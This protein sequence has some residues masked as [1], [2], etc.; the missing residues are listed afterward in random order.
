MKA[1]FTAIVRREEDQ[2]VAFSPELDIASQGSSQKEAVENLREAVTLFLET[3]SPQEVQGRLSEESWITQF[4]A[5][6]A[7]A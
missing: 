1:K 2:Y 3:A 6:Y 5:D 4:E 7:P